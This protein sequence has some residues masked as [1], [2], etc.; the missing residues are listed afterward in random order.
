MGCPRK[1]LNNAEKQA[2]AGKP[3]DYMANVILDE[4]MG[5]FVIR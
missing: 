4:K 2:V 3:G 1:A 5:S